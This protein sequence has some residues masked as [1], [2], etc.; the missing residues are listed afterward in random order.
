MKL[1]SLKSL[2]LLFILLFSIHSIAQERLKKQKVW[3]SKY[4]YETYWATKSN[5]KFKQGEYHFYKDSYL[6]VHGFYKD[7]RK[8]SLWTEY[9]I[10][11]RKLKEG[12]CLNDQKVGIWHEFTYPNGRFNYKYKV[13]KGKYEFNKRDSL[14]I[15]YNFDNTL[16][17]QSSPIVFY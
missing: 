16:N 1:L 10:Y 4:E 7:N 13:S 15:S 8:D 9:D 11:D 6:R 17:P 14:W 2:A 3:T 12:R 5:P